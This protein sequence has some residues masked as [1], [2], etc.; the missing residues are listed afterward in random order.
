MDVHLSVILDRLLD[1]THPLRGVAGNMVLRGLDLSLAE[2][3]VPKIHEK[4]GITWK[5]LDAVKGRVATAADKSMS[6]DVFLR[7]DCAAKA[8]GA[9][10]RRF[11]LEFQVKSTGLDPEKPSE[12][13]YASLANEMIKSVGFSFDT[14]NQPLVSMDQRRK[15]YQV[16][17]ETK[18]A[19]KAPWRGIPLADRA[20]AAAKCKVWY[21][22]VADTLSREL[23]EAA[24][25]DCGVAVIPPGALVSG[26]RVPASMCVLVPSPS[27]FH[28]W[29]PALHPDNVHS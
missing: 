1:G 25:A 16:E 28:M 11:V 21:C 18:K 12:N 27:Y 6:A 22:L 29:A 20:A 2:R 19:E 9:G 4:A 8:G 5:Q 14:A 23:A 3:G 17:K 15:A 24:E 7:A 13:G 26:M 10:R